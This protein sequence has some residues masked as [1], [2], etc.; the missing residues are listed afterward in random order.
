MDPSPWPGSSSMSRIRTRTPSS[1]GSRTWRCSCRGSGTWRSPT[2]CSSA[3]SA[4]GAPRPPSR[5]GCRTSPGCH[6]GRRFDRGPG[7]IRHHRP[8]PPARADRA[9]RRLPRNRHPGGSAD[10]HGD[11]TSWNRLGQ[12][13]S[14]GA[15][16]GNE[17]SGATWRVKSRPRNR[18]WGR[19]L[20]FSLARV[21]AFP[22]LPTQLR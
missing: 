12:A 11:S 5:C 20:G 7:M 19:G 17:A 6:R 13:P 1:P 15:D 18:N 2:S 22:R 16:R 8:R 3:R 21:F 9:R 14:I 10:R 4:G